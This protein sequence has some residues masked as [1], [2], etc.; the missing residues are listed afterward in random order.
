MKNFRLSRKLLMGAAIACALSVSMTSCDDDD[1]DPV[2]P[3]TTPAATS[4]AP[5]K[6]VG[7]D[8]TSNTTWSKDTIY[9]L[10][11]RIRVVPG[12]TLTINPG[13]IIKGA[14]G[15][16]AN[17]KVLM[18]MRDAKI[19]ADGT[20][21]EPII[22][23][24]IKDNIQPGQIASPNL[25]NDLTG[26]WG[27]LA[28]LGNGIIASKNRDASGSFD[29][30][31]IEGV[32]A[33]DTTG[34][35]GGT[36]NA[37]NSGIL[38]YV[39]VRHGGTAIGAGNEL[40]GIS[41]GGVGSGT[42]VENIEIVANAD[43]GVE[44][45]GG[46]VNATNVLVWNNGDDAVDTDNGYIGTI[47][48]GFV[49]GPVGSCFEL[50]GPEGNTTTITMNHT[51]KN[52]TVVPTRA[53]GTN[54]EDLLNFDAGTNITFQNVHYVSPGA[55][56]LNINNVDATN[57]SFSNI[58][59]NVSAASLSNYYNTGDAGLNAAVAVGTTGAANATPFANWTWAGTANDLNALN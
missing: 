35:Y 39:S 24:S 51:I 2:T 32:P 37:D 47:D 27:G 28:I 21:S 9:V 4:G 13:T 34:L 54:A 40:N 31:Q 45:Y 41:F 14:E 55:Q 46:A 43:D 58:T 56:V 6:F 25:P 5:Q 10:T 22:F 48:N 59:L 44:F 19:M 52:F 33:T 30:Q 26:Q 15:Q 18:V 7:L 29:I 8:I 11:S 23:T 12:V 53:D 17:A 38:R 3:S 36:N 16:G 1:D 20:A 49:V 50:D 42:I 57:G